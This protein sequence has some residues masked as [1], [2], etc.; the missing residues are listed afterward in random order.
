VARLVCNVA[1]RS[2]STSRLSDTTPPLDDPRHV[3]QSRVGCDLA[4]GRLRFG[5]GREVCP[6]DDGSSHALRQLIW[7]A[8]LFVLLP[9]DEDE[10]S[11]LAGVQQHLTQRGLSLRY[12]GASALICATSSSTNATRTLGASPSMSP[13]RVVH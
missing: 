10:L 5:D 13:A 12:D 7:C 6:A 8:G 9:A 3:E 4:A 1:T 11:N 2:I